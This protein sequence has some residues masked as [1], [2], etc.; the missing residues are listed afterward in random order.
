M[1]FH[2]A[3]SYIVKNWPLIHS[4]PTHFNLKNA[5]PHLI[6]KQQQCRG[7]HPNAVYLSKQF[8]TTPSKFIQKQT[9]LQTS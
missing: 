6:E 3:K 8:I 9:H 7:I 2:H 1:T 4:L 5:H